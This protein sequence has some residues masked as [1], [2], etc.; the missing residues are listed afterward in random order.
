MVRVTFHGED[1]AGFAPRGPGA[2]VKLMF[3]APG[4]DAPVMPPPGPDGRPQWPE[5][6]PRPPVR[7]YTPRHFNPDTLELDVEFVIH[8]D[9][10]ASTW[11]SQASEG[12]RLIVMGPGGGLEMRSDRE[13][14]VIAADEPAIPAA[15]TLLE[16]LPAG[17]RAIVLLEVPDPA[18]ERPLPTAAEVDVTWLH[19]GHDDSAAGTLLEPALRDLELPPGPGHLWV[20]CEAGVMRRIRLHWLHDRALPCEMVTTRGYWKRGAVDHPD[21]DYGEDIE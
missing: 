13:W 2:H 12:Q 21:H 14:Y 19:R 15:A 18:E 8:G 1:L 5:N 9:G 3:P 10:P 4:E 16:A 6:A 7:T 20:A 17:T 11:A